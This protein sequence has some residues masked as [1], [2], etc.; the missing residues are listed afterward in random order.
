LNVQGKRP[1][2]LRELLREGSMASANP[3]ISQGIAQLVPGFAP[4]QRD[5]SE[6][7]LGEK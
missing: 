4:S 6:Q 1:P 3:A 2:A 5:K 7:G